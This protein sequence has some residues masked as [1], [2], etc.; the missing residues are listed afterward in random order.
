MPKPTLTTFSR[1]EA[2]FVDVNVDDLWV[3]RITSN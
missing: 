2:R 3:N 1:I